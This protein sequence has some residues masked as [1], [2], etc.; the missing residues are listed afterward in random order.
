[1]VRAVLADHI[2]QYFAPPAVAEVRINI[3]HA[4]PLRIQETLKEQVKIQGIDVRNVQQVRHNGTRR[5]APARPDRDGIR[6]AVYIFMAAAV[7]DKI[8]HDEEIGR[9]AHLLD[10]T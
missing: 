8:P 10:D 1:M 9:I 7:M 2:I 5:T 6:I 4:D 3:G